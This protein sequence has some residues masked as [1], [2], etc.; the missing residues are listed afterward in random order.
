MGSELGYKS[1]VSLNDFDANQNVSRSSNERGKLMLMLIRYC[2][3][4][5]PPMT[6]VNRKYDSFYLVIYSSGNV[7][8][9]DF[10]SYVHKLN[11]RYWF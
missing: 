11:L 6:E 3:I 10:V 5:M 7:C 8:F 9:P 2:S 1:F 4:Q